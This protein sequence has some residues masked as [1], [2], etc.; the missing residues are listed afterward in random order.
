MRTGSALWFLFAF[1]MSLLAAAQEHSTPSETD[2]NGKLYSSHIYHNAVLGI[3]VALPGT[4]QTLQIDSTFPLLQQYQGECTGPLCRPS[5]MDAL[6]SK[7]DESPIHMFALI[8]FK[9]PSQYLDRKRYPLKGMAEVLLKKPFN[10]GGLSPV[11]ELTPI[12]FQ[13]RPAYRLLLQGIA[14]NTRERAFAH[15]GESNNY[16]FMIFASEQSAIAGRSDLQSAIEQLQFSPSPPVESAQISKFI[17]PHEPDNKELKGHIFEER[18]YEN[19]LLGMKITL[20]GTWQF[21]EQTSA[22]NE[23]QAECHEPFCNSFDV[24]LASKI[25]KLPVRTLFL[26]AY[27]P[28]LPFLDRSRYPLKK[29]AE[30]MT[31]DS[32]KDSGWL[33]SGDLTAVD[34]QGRPAYRLLA[35]QSYPQSNLPENAAV[36]FAYVTESNGYVFML[37]GVEKPSPP[38]GKVPELQFAI[39]NMQLTGSKR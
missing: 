30:A 11:G 18:I 15:I 16:V 10:L 34:L 20:P 9:L 17:Q 19:S 14:G 28:G 5:M 32:M 22:P 29:F 13:G 35:H 36:A 31:I 21:L 2:L 23:R 4:W 6:I 8:G 25:G 38:G 33:P 27:K 26:Q 39:E 12:Q 3:T 24:A 1:L 37:L 7:V